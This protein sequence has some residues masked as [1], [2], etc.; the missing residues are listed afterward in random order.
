[1]N[2][3]VCPNCGHCPVCGAPHARP[4]ENPYY[5]WVQRPPYIPNPNGTSRPQPQT[6]PV[7]YC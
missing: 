4:Q 2:Q 5:P 6:M 1:M 7:T 3:K